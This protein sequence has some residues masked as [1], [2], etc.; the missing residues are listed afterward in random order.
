LE[1]HGQSFKYL[2]EAMLALFGLRG[3]WAQG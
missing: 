1:E 3:Q 2:S